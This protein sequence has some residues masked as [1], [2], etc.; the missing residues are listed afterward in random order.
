[1]KIPFDKAP[2]IS[3]AQLL[4]HSFR[5][6]TQGEWHY[7]LCDNGRMVMHT[8]FSGLTETSGEHWSYSF[9]PSPYIKE[10]K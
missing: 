1:M 6:D 2:K 7:L 10:L 4:G 9:R 8:Q 3:F 5:Q